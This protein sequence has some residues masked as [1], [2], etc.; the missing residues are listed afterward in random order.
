MASAFSPQTPILCYGPRAH[1]RPGRRRFLLWPAWMFRV[2]AHLPRE[3]TLNILQRAVLDLCQ[4]GI[5]RATEVGVRLAIAEQFA[6]HV[7]RELQEL[8]ALSQEGEPT[9]RGRELLE[10][11]SLDGREVVSGYV[12]LAPW[13]REL[14]PRMVVREEPQ[15]I[16][17][18]QG[19][20]VSPPALGDPGQPEHGVRAP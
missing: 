8:G 9:P 10:V 20:W 11:D 7:L 17:P 4:V 2:L 12:F 13:T 18:R 15:A 16:V 6:A 19:Q 14:W 1:V 3:R 5:H